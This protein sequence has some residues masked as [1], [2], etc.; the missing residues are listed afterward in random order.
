MVF[1]N[2]QVNGKRCNIKRI[3]HKYNTLHLYNKQQ[4]ILHKY[5]TLNL[6]NKDEVIHD[7]LLL[8]TNMLAANFRKC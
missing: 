4:R 3:L 5:N 6:Y 7:F 8:L 2:A 1:F